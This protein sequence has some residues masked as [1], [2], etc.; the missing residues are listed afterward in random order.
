MAE[1]LYRDP[2]TGKLSAT[3]RVPFSEVIYRQGSNA[4]FIIELSRR[5]SELE[6]RG[7]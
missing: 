7:A 4:N 6:Q 3:E 1:A 5:I 2:F